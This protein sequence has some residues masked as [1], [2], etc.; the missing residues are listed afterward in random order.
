MKHLY[1]AFALTLLNVE[2]WSAETDAAPTTQS[3]PVVVTATRTPQPLSD[4][5]QPVRVITHEE[6]LE[7]GQDT[8]AE[9]LQTRGGVE[10][11]SNGGPGQTSTVFIRGANSNQTLVLLDG[12]R[13]NSA[14]GGT[15][16]FENIPLNQIARIEIVP[17]PMS[18]LYG[19]DALGGVIQIFTYRWP[20]A[21]KVT[22][23]AA[24]GTYNTSNVYGGVSAAV[25]DTSFNV[26]AGYYQTDG[27][28]ATNSKVPFGAFNPDNDGYRNVNGSASIVHRFSPGQEIGASAFY[29]EGNTHYDNGAGTDDVNHEIVDVY[30]LYTRNR[31]TSWWES[32]LRVSQSDDELQ[33]TGGAFPDSSITSAQTQ[34]TWQNTFPTTVGTFVGGVEYLRQRVS[35]TTEFTV[36]SREIY[37]GFVSY[38]GDFG[39]HALQASLRDDDN[40]QFGNQTTGALGYAYRV[41]SELRARASAGTAFHAPSFF[42][43]YDPFFGNPDLMPERSKSWEAGLDYTV[44]EQRFSITY[45]E[46]NISDLIVFDASINKTAN[47]NEA[48]INGVE[49]AYQGRV[50]GFD[51]GLRVTLQNPENADTGKQ[52]PRRAEDFGSLTVARIFGRWKFGGEVL[53]NGPR[54]DSVDENPA[55][56]LPGYGIVNLIATYAIA[57][58]WKVDV[59]WNNI[60]D[61]DYALAYGYNTPGTNVFVALTYAMK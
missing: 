46:N 28:S 4:T 12:V 29:T 37:S 41:T 42:D 31:L 54:F 47:L 33:F 36:D 26:N 21:P 57:K 2:A 61:K 11:A 52:L 35:G 32:L 49:L 5:I 8:L 30:A 22:A 16:S 40:S 51:I 43:L 34:V 45:F 10:I 15:A 14:A 44:G 17:G 56:R 38:T 25:G 20:D 13:I 27:F 59:R 58:D 3:D 19:S 23:T 9:V 6:I 53:A 48:N 24:V 60:F 1:A 55:T 7:S 18:S 50:L 39:K